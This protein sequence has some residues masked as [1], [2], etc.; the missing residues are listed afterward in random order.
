MRCG[1]DI[2]G[3]MHF[4]LCDLDRSRAGSMTTEFELRIDF[5]RD[6]NGGKNWSGM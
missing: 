2:F 6:K 1:V 3:A 5:Y 4:S